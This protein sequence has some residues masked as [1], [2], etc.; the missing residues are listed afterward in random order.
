M[1]GVSLGQL[2]VT[3]NRLYHCSSRVWKWQGLRDKPVGDDD[4]QTRVYVCTWLMVSIQKMVPS[5]I[6]MMRV[7]S[8]NVHSTYFTW[9]Q[10]IVVPWPEKYNPRFNTNQIELIILKEKTAQEF[11]E[12]LA[13]QSMSLIL[14]VLRLKNVWYLAF[15]CINVS[16]I[17]GNSTTGVSIIASAFHI[18]CFQKQ[19]A[20]S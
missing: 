15:H 10:L 11:W 4:R 20:R 12:A 6:I 3:V 7:M 8:T 17:S 18:H 1:S 13:S 19:E 14:R 9:L 16:A 2:W 5:D